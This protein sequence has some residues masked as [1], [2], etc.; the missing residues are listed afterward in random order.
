[1]LFIDIIN[2]Q[3]V[4][5]TTVSTYIATLGLAWTAVTDLSTLLQ[6]ADVFQLCEQQPLAPIPDLEHLP[7][8]PW[9]HPCTP[10]PD[11]ALKGAEGSWPPAE[12]PTEP[13]GKQPEALPP[14]VF[15]VVF[16]SGFAAVAGSDSNVART[17][18]GP[19]L[20]F[21][22]T[23]NSTSPL[24]FWSSDFKTSRSAARICASVG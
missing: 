23:K 11:P 12:K 13:A 24:S 16:D 5:V 2:A 7:P 6:T 14:T 22:T 8:L 3:Q 10:L 18:D 15:V 9:C 1:M 21:S 20:V 4:L 19:L 17:F